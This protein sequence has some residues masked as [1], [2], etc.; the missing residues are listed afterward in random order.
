VDKRFV[1]QGTKRSYGRQVATGHLV[2]AYG[3]F[4]DRE[5]VFWRPGQGPNKWQLLG[6]R[7]KN[8]G[9]LRVCDFRQA[10]GLYLLFDDYGASYVGLARGAQGI[11]QR[12]KSHDADA[13]KSWS[14]FCWFCFDNVADASAEGWSK[15]VP[16]DGVRAAGAEGIVR[17]LE[18]LLIKVLG[19]RQQNQMRFL[20]ADPW[21][22]VTLADC[23]PGECLT[24]VERGPILQPEFA[25]AI[26]ELSD[27][28][29]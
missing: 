24:K 9:A 4:W 28:D 14:R 22:Q 20:E 19:A 11:G 15:V 5:E 8:Q 18:A 12:L 17:E 3:M 21:Q 16:R 1:A 23:Q 26:D 29:S 27:D 6:R 10:K 13:S 2:G 25:R 7:N